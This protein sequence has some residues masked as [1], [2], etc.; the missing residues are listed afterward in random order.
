MS[1]MCFVQYLPTGTLENT[2]PTRLALN[3]PQQSIVL[4]PGEEISVYARSALSKIIVF[5]VSEDGKKVKC[6]IC[7]PYIAR[8]D[9]Q[10]MHRDSYTGHMKSQAHQ[11]YG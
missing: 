4:P 10:W 9:K 11:E 1:A 6:I 5:E 2:Q 8:K 7:T 3:M